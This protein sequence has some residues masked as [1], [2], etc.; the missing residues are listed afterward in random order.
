M[1]QWRN[2]LIKRIVVALGLLFV[3][4]PAMAGR[5]AEPISELPQVPAQVESG[6][7]WN[8][9]WPLLRMTTALFTSTVL[10]A[11]SMW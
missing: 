5:A 1:M 2:R 3:P 9:K 6:G 11:G 8:L 7:G 4:P 10:V